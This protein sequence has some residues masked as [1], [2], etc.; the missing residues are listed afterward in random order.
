VQYLR[1]LKDANGDAKEVEVGAIVSLA[2]GTLDPGLC[3][4]PSCETQC[5]SQAGK[6]A[7][8][9]RCTGVPTFD[10]CMQDCNAECHQFCGGQVPGRRY[11]DLAYAFDGFAANIC[12]DDASGPLGRLAS[13][14]GIPTQVLLRATPQSQQLMTVR[15]LRG[16]QTI[17][18]D[19][20]TGYQMVQTVDGQAVRF[21]GDCVLQPDDTYD[22]RYLAT[23]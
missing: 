9:A 13:V 21:A 1:S 14:I 4:N 7:C 22:L 10:V 6:D 17:K 16:T 8:T 20:G 11:V 2:N 23:R 18:C 12:S 5:D 19:P 3:T 15:V